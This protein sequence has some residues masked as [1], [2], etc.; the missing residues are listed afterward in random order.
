M[1]LT[2]NT[3]LITG[4]TSG[5]GLAFARE[6]YQRK[7][8]VIICGRRTGRLKQIAEKYPGII[9]K[10]SDISKNN[11]RK[12]LAAWAISNYSDINILINN[13]GV[14]YV[15]DLKKETDID[16]LNS[17][18]NTNLVAPVH[19]ASLFMKQLETKTEAAIINV[20]SG[21][22]FVPIAL[23][24]VYCATKAGIHSYTMSLRHQLKDTS[25]RVFE[26]IPPAVDT[27]LGHERRAD[28]SQT[29]GGM[30]VDTFIKEVM[31]ALEND[32]YDMPIENA[33]NLREKNEQLFNA[34]NL[35]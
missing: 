27:E 17:E 30:P 9:T 34:I 28:K 26:V 1:N 18:V 2:K 35:R 24:P 5:I 12:E 19:L 16:K 20:S 6:F 8:T 10:E 13:A 31:S 22:A 32:V 11:E 3:V 21:L 25:V 14:Q 29:H 15:F 7:N 23:M 4:G 33:K